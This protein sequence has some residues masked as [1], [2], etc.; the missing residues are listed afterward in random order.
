MFPPSNTIRARAIL[1]VAVWLCAIWTSM[2]RADNEIDIVCPCKVESSN[3]TSVTVSFGIRNWRT[4]SDTGPLK[5]QLSTRAVDSERYGFDRSEFELPAVPA[6]STRAVRSYTTA[7]R[8][9]STEEEPQE[10]T[11]TI[12]SVATGQLVERIRWLADPVELKGG[13]YTSPSILMA[14]PRSP[15]PANRLR[16][17]FR[18]SRTDCTAAR[19]GALSC[20]CGPNPLQLGF[21]CGRS[22][23]T[24]W[25]RDLIPE[26]RFHP[27]Q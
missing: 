27:Q 18:H 16:S 10:L 20:P 21:V 2:A 19:W 3:P 22:E 1:A 4:D 14:Y 7:F 11:L 26:G 25:A 17:N 13:G 5:A 15:S 6:N 9:W 24:I 8:R 12:Y 23:H